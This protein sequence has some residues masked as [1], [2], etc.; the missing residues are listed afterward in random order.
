ME[1]EFPLKLKW[2]DEEIYQNAIKYQNDEDI[3]EN[4]E[5][6]STYNPNSKWDWYDIGGRF[7]NQLLTKIENKDT[8]ERNS[9]AEY[10]SSK[11]FVREAPKGFKYVN[12]AKIKDIDFEFMDELNKEPFYTWAIVDEKN[13]YEQGEMGWWGLNNATE[14]STKTFIDKFKKIISDVDNQEKYLIIVDCHI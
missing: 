5:L 6:Y 13:W 8:F 1:E 12:G 14:E 9:F 4:G 11:D 7:R 2:S 10:Y 3:R